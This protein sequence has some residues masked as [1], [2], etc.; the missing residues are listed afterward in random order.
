ME[1]D[2][3]K[4]Q[5]GA[6]DRSALKRRHFVQLKHVGEAAS[7]LHDDSD[8]FK[9]PHVSHCALDLVGPPKSVWRQKFK[10]NPRRPVAAP[11]RTNTL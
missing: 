11:W 5:R 4:F 3:C 10:P 9:G 8:P 6:K 2:R 1:R 7:Y